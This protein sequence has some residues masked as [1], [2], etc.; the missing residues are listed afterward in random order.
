M[1]HSSR[2][3]TG[4]ITRASLGMST[5]L[6]LAFAASSCGSSSKA[7]SSGD[8]GASGNGCVQHYQSGTDYFPAKATVATAHN[9]SLSY[10]HN[11]KVL[12]VRNAGEN[13]NT[14]ATYVL[15]QCGTPAPRRT[16]VLAHATLL[17]IPVKRIVVSSTTQMGAFEELGTTDRVVGIDSTAYLTGKAALAR[18]PKLAQFAPQGTPNAETLLQAQPDVVIDDGFSPGLSTTTRK[19]HLPD[20]LDASNQEQDPLGRA[21]WL[22]AFAALTDQEATANTSYQSVANAYGTLKT[23]A[24]GVGAAARPYVMTGFVYQGRWSTSGGKSYEARTIDDAGGR[25]VW[26]DNSSTGPVY[27]SLEAEL[28]K[29]HDADFWING[30]LYWTSHTQ[31]LSEEPRYRNF[32]AWQTQRVWNNDKGANAN[33]GQPYQEEGPYRPDLVLGDLVAIFHPNL[34]PHHQ[35]TYYRQLPA[36]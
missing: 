14:T 8:T 25:Y 5:A 10:H 32:K 23:K 24:A 9:F 30:S 4:K 6:L 36:G 12:T 33:G 13:A 11:Y 16:G 28:N 19:A 22:K 1:S 7:S 27:V 2:H 21:E 35:F 15:V 29:A 18:A 20:F 26:A 3:Q 34:A 31:M 17:T